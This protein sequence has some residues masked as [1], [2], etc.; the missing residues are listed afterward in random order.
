MT[1]AAAARAE[2]SPD[3]SMSTQYGL[4]S[5]KFAGSRLWNSQPTSISNLNSLKLFCKALEN[6]MLSPYTN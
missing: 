2:P 6:S 3:Q 1:P 5:L 4:R